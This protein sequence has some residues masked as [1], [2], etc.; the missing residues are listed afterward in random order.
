MKGRKARFY[1]ITKAFGQT[2]TVK[3]GKTISLYGWVR[4][5]KKPTNLDLSAFLS[6]RSGGD[7][8]PRW[9]APHNISNVTPSTARTPLHVCFTLKYSPDTVSEIGQTFKA[10]IKNIQFSFYSESPIKSRF[11]VTT[12]VNG[13]QSF[14]CC[15]QHRFD[16]SRSFY[17]PIMFSMFH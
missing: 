2:Q 7:S 13:L 9:L 16:S 8:N 17:F 3:S 5:Y 14:Q 11:S 1:G 12:T 15:G 4:E 6:W 10:N